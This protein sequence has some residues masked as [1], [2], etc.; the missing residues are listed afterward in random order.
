MLSA[1]GANLL[2]GVLIVALGL[3]GIGARVMA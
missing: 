3:M 1:S 2:A